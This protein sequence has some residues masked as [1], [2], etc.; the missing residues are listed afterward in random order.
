MSKRICL[1]IGHGGND[2]GAINPHTKETE[3]DYNRDLAVRVEKL[4]KEQGYIVDIYNRGY[5][6]VENVNYLNK[7]GYDILVSLHCNAY[8][9]YASGTEVLYWN[10]S[11]KGQILAQALLDSITDVLG[12]Q[13]RGLKPIKYGDRG[14][15]LLGKTDPVTVLIEPFFIDNDNDFKVGKEKKDEYS[16]AIVRGINKYFQN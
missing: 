15:Y 5:A 2:C 10:T 7:I 3:L 1:I 13:N 11:K 6:K 8:N 4:L 16:E 12:L 14:A 9:G